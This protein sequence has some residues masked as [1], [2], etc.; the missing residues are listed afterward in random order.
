MSTDVETFA[1]AFTE[2]RYEDALACY[3]GPLFQG[4][5]RSQSPEFDSWLEY[6]REHLHTR[7][8]DVALERAAE[9]QREHRNLEAA[10]LYGRLLGA[11]ALDE[12][13]LRSY[14]QTLHQSGQQQQALKVYQAFAQQLNQELGM[15]PTTATEQLAEAIGQ[16]QA[17]TRPRVAPGPA[18]TV[19]EEMPT[20]P[21]VPTPATPFIGRDL[22]LSEIAHLL[23]QPTSRLLTLTGPGGVGKS[24]IAMQ[25]ME[26]LASRYPGGCHFVPLDALATPEGIPTAIARGL[27]LNLQAK[28][29]PLAQVIRQLRT[30]QLLLVLDNFEHLTEGAAVISRLLAECPKLTVIV[31]SQ[32]RLELLE[33][34]LLPMHGLPYP[35]DDSLS[36]QDALRYDAVRLLVEQAKRVNPRFELIPGELAPAID[37]CRLVNGLPLGIELAAVWTRLMPL[38]GIADEIERSLDFLSTSDTNRTARHRSIRAAFEHS[39]RLLSPREQEV[40]RKLSVFTGGFRKDAATVVAGASIAVLAALLDKS[41][42]RTLPNGRYDRHPLLYQYTKEK[43]AEHPEEALEMQGKHARYYLALA[44]RAAP[45]F[46][47]PQQA[48]WLQQLEEEHDNLRLALAQLTE[49]GSALEALE[50]A[51]LLG[52]FWRVHGHFSEGRVQLSRVLTL[53]GAAKPTLRRAKALMAA[54]GLAYEQADYSSAESAFREGL[55]IYRRH[56]DSQGVAASLSN[57]GMVAQRRHDHASASYYF[58]ESLKISCHLGDRWAIA[59]VLN[60]LGIVAFD[61][62]DYDAAR[63]YYQRSL[64]LERELGNL[65]GIAITL[66]NLGLVAQKQGD[67]PTAQSMFEEGLHVARQLGD[68]GGIARLLSNLSNIA[69]LQCRYE[70]ARQLSS[71]SLAIRW[72]LGSKLGIMDN[73]QELAM[74]ARSQGEHE[75]ATRLWAAAEALRECLGAHLAPSRRPRYEQ[76]IRVAT[77]ELG[78]A[79]FAAAWAKG[80]AMSLEQAVDYGMKEP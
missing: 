34:Q 41:L 63:E 18:A 44:E 74:L 76:D 5:D 24:R 32:A 59:Q 80:Q 51:G 75:R 79:A 69:R 29:E 62:L 53:A 23:N 8:R 3:Q 2:H 54:G 35:A 67:Y 66:N 55:A 31:T 49:S 38:A 36:V 50:L 72:G 10:E 13:A 43:L 40:L 47:G 78:R 77:T 70:A 73:L 33:E 61:Q 9:L 28:E 27:K 11:D 52:S 65:R 57:L 64:E 21:N 45:R 1:R 12:E 15:K 22:E 19:V 71:D 30:K 7:W 68:K 16:A 37:V 14:M 60:N 17:E 46:K 39:W 48:T 4:L 26:E 25:A 42:L 58:Q 6:E 56:G 20:Q